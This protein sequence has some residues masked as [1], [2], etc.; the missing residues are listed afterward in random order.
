MLRFLYLS[1]AFGD[2]TMWLALSSSSPNHHG[3]KLTIH[4]RNAATGFIVL[5]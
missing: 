5:K 1:A 3:R 2:I 4:A